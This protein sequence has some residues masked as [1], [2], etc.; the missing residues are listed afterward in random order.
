MGSG[1]VSSLCCQRSS[2]SACL[3]RGGGGGEEEEGRCAE[4]QRPLCYR[5]ELHKIAQP[6]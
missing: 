1:G 2:L 5:E 6:C 4:I 3:T